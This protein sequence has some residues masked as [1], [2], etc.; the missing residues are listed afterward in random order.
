MRKLFWL[1]VAIYTLA[2][3]GCSQV[4]L[5]YEPSLKNIETLKASNMAPATTGTFALA[6]GLPSSLDQSVSARAST[7]VSPNNNSFALFLKDALTKELVAAGKFDPHSPVVINGLLTKNS[8]DAPIGTG[9]G[10]LAAKFSVTRNGNSVYE[11]ELQETA[12]WKSGFL[13]A[14]AIPRAINEYTTLYK[15]LISQLFNDDNFKKAT[16]AD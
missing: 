8:L 1:I 9:K 3:T 15:K 7:V 12:E 11:K 4:P 13:G 14:E 5:A 10:V 16:K 6:P 2:L